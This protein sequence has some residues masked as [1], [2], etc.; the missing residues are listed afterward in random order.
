MWHRMKD[1]RN[2]FQ[3]TNKLPISTKNNRCQLPR[4]SRQASHRIQNRQD[5]SRGTFFPRFLRKTLPGSC[6]VCSNYFCVG[7]EGPC[8]RSQS[9]REPDSNS[10]HANRRRLSP[11]LCLVI[12]PMPMT[13]SQKSGP[14]YSCLW[15][16][17]VLLQSWVRYSSTFTVARVSR[18]Q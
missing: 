11:I 1:N 13:C 4:Y 3:L 18:P 2:K 5:K 17:L 9:S 7:K 16:A 10:I 8:S 6:S 12:R 14:G 15:P